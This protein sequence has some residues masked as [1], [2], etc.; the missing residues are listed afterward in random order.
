LAEKHSSLL[1]STLKTPQTTI[2]FQQYI[3]GIANGTSPYCYDAVRSTFGH[4]VGAIKQKMEDER[5]ARK[6]TEEEAARKK[7]AAARKKKRM[8]DWCRD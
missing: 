5:K 6:K 4:T 2:V 7:E 3:Q 1:A 8:D